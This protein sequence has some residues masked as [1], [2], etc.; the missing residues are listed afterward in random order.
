MHNIIVRNEVVAQHQ[1]ARSEYQGIRMRVATVGWLL[2]ASGVILLAVER[3]RLETSAADSLSWL[4]YG[5][6]A[7]LVLGAALISA[8]AF[9]YYSKRNEEVS[10]L[11]EI[12]AE[13]RQI[14]SDRFDL[15]GNTEHGDEN[16]NTK[17]VRMAAPS[18][19]AANDPEA[20][21]N[22]GVK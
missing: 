5:Y 18:G 1:H 7:F 15:L 8:S 16:K 20:G 19:T 6:N 21:L 11:V 4:A 10:R 2:F 14:R 13:L 3:V 17:V 12:D 22:R 9:H